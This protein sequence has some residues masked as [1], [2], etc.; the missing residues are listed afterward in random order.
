MRRTAHCVLVW[1][2]SVSFVT[3]TSFIVLSVVDMIG[4][5]QHIGKLMLILA[6]TLYNAKLTVLLIGLLICNFPVS[7]KI[8]KK[9]RYTEIDLD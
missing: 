8:Y 9:Y 5:V 7:L 6:K 1:L 2:V 4:V 3:R